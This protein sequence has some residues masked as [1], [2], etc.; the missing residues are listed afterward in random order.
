MIGSI[1]VKLFITLI[2]GGSAGL[3][4]IAWLNKKLADD[5]DRSYS[6]DFDPRKIMLSAVDHRGV[7]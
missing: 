5:C 7:S 4:L 6:R 2:G 3:Y 1:L